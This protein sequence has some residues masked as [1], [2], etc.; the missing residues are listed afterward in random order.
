[1]LYSVLVRKRSRA[2]TPA[3]VTPNE[4]YALSHKPRQQRHVPRGHR[5]GEPPV[6]Y[7]SGTQA[8]QMETKEEYE[9]M[10]FQ[11]EVIYEDPDNN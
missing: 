3:S 8:V 6:R 9:D 11:E 1:M 10:E 5:G 4:S 7:A 2:D